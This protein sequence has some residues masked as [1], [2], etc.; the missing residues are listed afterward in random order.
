MITRGDFRMMIDTGDGY[1]NRSATRPVAD[2]H[3]RARRSGL[4]SA[5]TAGGQVPCSASGRIAATAPSST[6]RSKQAGKGRRVA[7]ELFWR[8]AEL[9][10][11]DKPQSNAGHG[12]SCRQ[13]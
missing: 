7:G 9:K 6:S 10:G 4:H 3:G 12:V 2:A 5:T 1:D 11:K 13:I 8:K